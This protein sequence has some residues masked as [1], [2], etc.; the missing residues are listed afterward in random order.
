MTFKFLRFNIIL[1]FVLGTSTT[2]VYS[3]SNN[4][5]DQQALVSFKLLITE[6]PSGVLESWNNSFHFC[7]WTGITC[8]RSR[9]RVTV[10]DLSSLGLAGTLSPH[11]GNLSF[12][13]TIYLYENRL[14]GLIPS[15]IGRLFRLQHLSMGNN[16]F[17]GGF[18]ANLLHCRDIT[19]MN[20]ESNDLEGKLP[21]DFSSWSKLNV[22]SV[23]RNHFDGSIP[24]SIGNISSLRALYLADNT[25]VGEIPQEVAHLTK[26]E[27]L[28]LSGN[29]LSGMV[30][31][32]LYNISSLLSLGLEDNRFKGTL[33]PGFGF[34]QLPRLQQFSA[35]NNT[36]TGPLP[37]S[38]ANASNL[39]ILDLSFNNIIGPIPKNLGSLLN[40]EWLALGHNPLGEN[41]QSNEWSFFNSL[42]N[43][44]HLRTLG[45]HENSLRGELPSSIANLSTTVEDLYLYG[46]HIYGSIPHEI[47]K[48]VNMIHLNFEVNFLTGSIPQSIGRL[49]KLGG[50]YL[51]ENN[52][53]GV[54]PT[55]FSNIT[56][57]VELYLDGNVLQGS[58]P[59]KLFNISTLEDLFLA[60][61]MLRGV[62]PEEIVFLSHCI[63]LNLSQ[64]LVTG[65]LP[66]N[67]GSL[68]HLARLDLSYNKL[69][70]DIPAT[71]E[72]CLMLEELYMGG[73][74]FQGKIPSSFK[75]LKNL[76]YLDISNNNISGSIPSFFDGFHQ[77]IFLNLSHNKLEGEVS[78]EGLFSK[79]S[80]FSVVGNWEL[81]GGVQALHLP[82]CPDKVSRKKKK[83]FALRTI[84]IL[85]LVPLGVLLAC[86][87][88]ISY[89]R[90]N[91]KKL[92]EPVSGLKDDHYP[93]LSYQD[94]LLATNEFSPDNLIGEGRYGSVYKG[95]LESVEHLVAVKVLNGEIHGANKTFLAECET[96]RNIRHRNLIKIITACSSIDF[97]GN[98]FKALVFEFMTNG[99]LD[100]WLH[101]GPSYQ[102]YE[103]N[104][105]V[106]QRLN[107]SIDVALGIDYLH[108]HTHA[109]IIHCDLKPSNILLDE[110]FVARIGDFG[111]ARFCFSTTTDINQAQMSS[112]GVRGTVGYVPP[113]YGMFGEI[114]TKGDVYSYGILLLQIF[115]GKQPTDNSI[116]ID[117]G[118]NLHDY[119]KKALPQRVM[120]IA[121]PR[122]SLDQEEHG[123]TVNQ[124]YNRAIMEVCL[125]S[126][127]E[128]GLLCSE[129]LPQKR[130]DISV[131]IKKLHI[132]K[133]K[134]LQLRH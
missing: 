15:E 103:R 8:S 3:F 4:V 52:I 89:R 66:S 25:L 125:E 30:P 23:A 27:V 72:G 20:L 19:Y 102:G 132:A 131:A 69:T 90:L 14:H 130:I 115:S 110:N 29:R 47:G 84:L 127:F 2:F 92:N 64:N 63:S 1:I 109:C 105:S 53:S 126:I 46:N 44:T 121:D 62:I 40:I 112:T 91:Y 43:C 31:L 12:L 70:G 111:L 88:L 114:S 5:T 37:P 22:F 118:D 93:K 133:E 51:S 120:D 41:M 76:A 98:D 48:L 26:L 97:K 61:N 99:S 50:L 86:L 101:P 79:V 42:V 34:T 100:S 54:I 58:I 7:H 108:H 107:I 16:T 57:L 59:T 10:L 60:N 134:L 106:L 9:Q 38:I 39:V 119:V 13:R 17:Q 80:T 122:I 24:P 71:L 113:E 129:E 124:S 35:G 49:S 73:N 74:L 78:K 75:A 18:P 32:P 33:P 21:T 95:H 81:C 77:I 11:I 68:K 36:F 67:I 6:D 82:S 56:N 116:L 96:L 55:S 94:L 65:P 104:L 87:A 45:L 117:G 28:G 83:T 123:L 128:V 85:V